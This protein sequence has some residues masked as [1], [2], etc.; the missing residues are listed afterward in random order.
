MTVKD[1]RE[2][3]TEPNSSIHKSLN[4][5][6]QLPRVL[7]KSPSTK[8]K[9]QIEIPT[10]KNATIKQHKCLTR[11]KIKLA[12]KDPNHS[13]IWN[14]KFPARS[15]GATTNISNLRNSLLNTSIGQLKE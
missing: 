5:K 7:N 4:L 2:M 6:P 13:T 12:T 3:S 14:H 1:P 15:K 11:S 8:P 10:S 9:S